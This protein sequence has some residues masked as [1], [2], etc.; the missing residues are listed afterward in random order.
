MKTVRGKLKLRILKVIHDDRGVAMLEFALIALP[1]F[2]LIFGILEVGLI[3]WGTYEL[4]N[5]T[6]AAS[7]MIRTG[8]AQTN[9]TNQTGMIAQICSQALMLP[10]CTSN[11][12]LNVQRLPGFRRH[13]G[14]NRN[15]RQ[16]QP[17]D[18]LSIP[19]RRAVH[20]QSGDEL[21]RV[22]ADRP[23]PLSLLSNLSDGNRL[24]QSSAVFRTEPY[25][26]I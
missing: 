16:W 3:F 2:I 26:Q 18:E 11:L 7:R 22:A 8:Q 9:N 13:H 21:L 6:L 23:S 19:A 20:G 25:P 17:A 15:R 4:D 1:L 5:A 24:L 14:S 12:R 10:N